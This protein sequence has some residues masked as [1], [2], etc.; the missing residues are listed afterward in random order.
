M[1]DVSDR[2]L[3]LHVVLRVSDAKI[4]PTSTTS[5]SREQ[6]MLDLSECI[7]SSFYFNT[8]KVEFTNPQW[9]KKTYDTV[10]TSKTK[11]K[12]FYIIF[13][14]LCPSVWVPFFL[15]AQYFPLLVPFLKI[16]LYPPLIFVI[17]C[18]CIHYGL[19]L[20]YEE[21]HLV[22]FWVWVT[23][24]NILSRSIHFPANVMISFSL[25]LSNIPYLLCMPHQLTDSQA[26]SIPLLSWIEQ[27]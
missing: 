13:Y 4:K 5:A 20:A 11:T 14:D 24:R 19:G 23:L 26:G 17:L 15:I 21:E 25:Q 8:Q 2:S 1:T 6:C 18:T 10:E 12:P 22:Y 7:Y 16:R 9:R 27:Q 3:L